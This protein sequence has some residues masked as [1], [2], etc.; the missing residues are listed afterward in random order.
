MTSF[1][2]DL[3]E[4]SPQAN[5]RLAGWLANIRVGWKLALIISVL[6]LGILGIFASAFAGLRELSNQ[7]NVMYGGT[8][9][10]ITSLD[11][12]DIALGNIEI[13]LAALQN[14]TLTQ[15]EK[16]EIFRNLEIAESLFNSIF[17]RY[18]LSSLNAAFT[19]TLI[20][21]ERLELQ[22]EELSSY[23][24]VKLYYESYTGLRNKLQNSLQAEKLDFRVLSSS[25]AAIGAT[26][27][28]LR[29]IT[30]L[31]REFADFSNN[32]AQAA[33]NQALLVMVVTLVVSALIGLVLAWIVVRSITSRLGFLTQVAHSLQNGDLEYRAQI[34]V[35]GN[36]EIAELAVAFDSMAEQLAQ[37]LGGLE[38][39]VTERT[40]ELQGKTKELEQRSVQ[41]QAVSDI[42]RAMA[43]IQTIHELLPRIVNSISER[44]GYYHA[45]IYLLN[46]AGDYVILNA[47]SSDGGQLLLKNQHRLPVKPDSL[48]GFAASR[49]KAR[50]VRDVSQDAAYLALPELPETKSEAV[51]PL[52]AGTQ[53]I[54]VLDVQ[55]LQPGAFSEQDVNVLNTLA[56]Q[57]AISIQNARSFGETRQALAQAEKIYQQ[58]VQLGWNRISQE[59]PNLGYKFSQEG[60]TALSLA[61][62]PFKVESTAAN[63]SIPIKLRGQTIGTMRVRSTELAHEWDPDEMAM[64]QATAERSALAL[65]TAR[66][67]EDSQ[68]RASRERAI[69]EI[70]SKISEKSDIDAILRSTAEEL[71]KKLGD[72]EIT[73]EISEIT[74]KQA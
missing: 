58:F 4:Q 55:S 61:D 62:E 52:M 42:S 38:Q 64:I 37:T 5:S 74:E 24:N 6:V 30:D 44:L 59:T 10:P 36:D 9:L 57:I 71:G 27:G 48:V 20:S 73:V 15:A 12:A 51:I 32:A 23:S 39:R 67:L 43:S 45:G 22:Q 68:R 34:G 50:V 14:P 70:S 28:Y 40:A 54:G 47:A 69:G 19:Q 49:G 72:A 29:N 66:L 33:Y 17:Q 13:E 41:L 21:E 11:R 25:Q 18:Q 53:L 3:P 16:V 1:K 8:L 56:S 7:I 65:E 31:N 2:R 60:I 26:R 46:E 63:L 35:G